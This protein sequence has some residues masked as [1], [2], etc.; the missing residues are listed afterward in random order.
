M[1]RIQESPSPSAVGLRPEEVRSL[2]KLL[3]ARKAHS[4]RVNLG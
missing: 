4:R 2:K 1:K 3:L